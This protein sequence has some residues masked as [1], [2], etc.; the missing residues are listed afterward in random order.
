M[1]ATGDALSPGQ[2]L[3]PVNGVCGTS[4]GQTLTT[5]PTNLCTTGTASQIASASF[6]YTWSC[7]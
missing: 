6:S 2:D 7:A 1:S 5:L 4:S 3:I